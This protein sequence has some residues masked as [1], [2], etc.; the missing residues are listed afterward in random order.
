MSCAIAPQQAQRWRQTVAILTGPTTGSD[1]GCWL[2]DRAANCT[3]LELLVGDATKA[4]ASKNPRYDDTA[5]GRLLLSGELCSRPLR[6]AIFGGSNTGAGTDI[7][8]AWPFFWSREL[9]SEL[10]LSGINATVDNFGL[11]ATGVEYWIRCPPSHGH[12]DLVISE[13]ALNEQDGY[14]IHTPHH[15]VHL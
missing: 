15:L 11:P 10:A 2:V 12:W 13:F 14:E 6:I 3:S 1:G 9:R 7:Y 8:N 4:F 5:L